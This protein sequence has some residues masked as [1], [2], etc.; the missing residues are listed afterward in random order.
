M[1]MNVQIE[2]MMIFANRRVKAPNPDWIEDE[3]PH[4]LD[5]TR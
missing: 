3:R 1:T 4:P 5:S 2:H